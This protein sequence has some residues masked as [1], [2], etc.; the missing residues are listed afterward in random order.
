MTFGNDLAPGAFLG[1]FQIPGF[2]RNY[3]TIPGLL[4]VAFWLQVGLCWAQL[5]VCWG[6]SKNPKK[7]YNI[8]IYTYSQGLT[9]LVLCF[10]IR[11]SF[12]LIFSLRR[13][14]CTSRFVRVISC[15]RVLL[16]M[17]LFTLL[18]V[19]LTKTS[20]W[21]LNITLHKLPLLANITLHKLDRYSRY[22]LYLC[23]CWY[24]LVFLNLKTSHSI[25]P[26]LISHTFNIF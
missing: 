5:G 8:Y 9:H 19:C 22:V 3:I 10:L 14:V 17:Q 15:A 24:Y 25:K 20:T 23:F 4:R 7:K 12:M 21:N 2:P 1:R 11:V 6:C 13:L 26:N 18:D 16:I